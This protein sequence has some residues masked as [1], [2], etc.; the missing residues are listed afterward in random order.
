MSVL[1]ML[2]HL[3]PA[4]ERTGMENPLSLLVDI[5][6]MEKQPFLLVLEF[7]MKQ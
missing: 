3:T 1:T 6:T 2:L 4:I 5:T 7:V